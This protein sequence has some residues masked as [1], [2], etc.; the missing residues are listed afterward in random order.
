[1]TTTLRARAVYG[2]SK[3]KIAPLIAR[4]QS[5]HDGMAADTATYTAP[6][7]LLPAFQSL[8]QNLGIAEQAVKAR[9]AGAALVRNVQRDILFT[10]MGTELAYIQSLADA[11]ASASHAASIIVNAGLV[12]AKV[13]AH[14][15]GVIVLALT[16]QP[17]TVTCDA[18]V[19]LL[20]GAGAKKPNESRFFNWSYTV[21][22]KTFITMPPT[23]TGKTTIQNIPLFTTVG[24]RVNLN[25][26]EGPGEWSQVVSILV[27]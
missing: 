21:D 24:V 3:N 10:A 27:H 14:T 13:P 20:V 22:G 25:N 12:V 16:K 2:V 8:I 4:A 1:M 9:A 11:S 5:M 18:N 17:G 7:P 15:K 19:G 23:P 26:S 6:N